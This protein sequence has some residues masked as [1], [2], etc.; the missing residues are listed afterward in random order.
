MRWSGTEN[1]DE[2]IEGMTLNIATTRTFMAITL[3][4]SIHDIEETT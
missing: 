3:C 4:I 2:E 1:K